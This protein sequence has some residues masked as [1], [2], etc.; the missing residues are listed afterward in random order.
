[1]FVPLC[2]SPSPF[3]S[4]LHPRQ[5]MAFPGQRLVSGWSS[6]RDFYDRLDISKEAHS[7]LALLATAGG[8]K[9]Q[10]QAA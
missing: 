4:G 3:T 8:G 1:M 10:G 6:H 2:L 5:H 9:C 7:W